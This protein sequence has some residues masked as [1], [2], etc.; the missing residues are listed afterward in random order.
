MTKFRPKIGLPITNHF[1]PLTTAPSGP[2][3]RLQDLFLVLSQRVDLGL[4]AVTA[5]FGA[6]R[7]LKKVF[8]SGF[9]IIGIRV[10]QCKI[11]VFFGL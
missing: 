4:L 1:S 7:N 6:A 5:A 10:S 2:T 9:E 8:G 11:R 3:V